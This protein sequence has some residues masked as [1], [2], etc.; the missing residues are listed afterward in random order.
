MFVLCMSNVVVAEENV[1]DVDASETTTHLQT[2][3][4]LMPPY[5]AVTVRIYGSATL[6][7]NNEMV[8]NGETFHIFDDKKCIVSMQPEYGFSLVSL[9]FEGEP[10]VPI[11][12]TTYEGNI[13]KDGTLIAVLS[14]WNA[15]I[16]ITFSIA[17]PYRV[18]V[19]GKE[20]QDQETMYCYP[21]E[22]M[23]LF[24]DTPPNTDIAVSLNGKTFTEVDER[25]YTIS[26]MD[27]GMLRIEEYVP[28]KREE[29]SLKRRF[30]RQT[31]APISS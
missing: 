12:S 16:P 26:V 31:P 10:L 11:S 23:Q 25:T 8:H 6:T 5:S 27:P 17:E 22:E 30:A 19:Y 9:E 20:V 13:Q 1:A 28:V 24:I 15:N 3:D 4:A 21:K 18:Y 14:R 2:S 7:I 29:L